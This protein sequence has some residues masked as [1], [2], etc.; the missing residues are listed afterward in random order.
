[1]KKALTIGMASI[2]LAGVLFAGAATAGATPGRTTV[3]SNCHHASTAVKLTVTKVSST[4]K[5]V[6]YKVSVTGG[7]GTARGQSC[8]A[9]R[10]SH[11]GPLRRAR[12][13]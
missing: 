10:T 8:P 7:K 6:T 3:C 2:A 1:M 5:T 9:A 11:I 12:S 13:R 4:A